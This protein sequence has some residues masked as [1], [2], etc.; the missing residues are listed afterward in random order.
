LSFRHNASYEPEALATKVGSLMSTYG[1]GLLQ[2]VR[3]RY[4]FTTID[5]PSN[6]SLYFSAGQWRS[7]CAISARSGS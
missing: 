6:T 2:A 4:G 1:W 5:V 7:G 3:D